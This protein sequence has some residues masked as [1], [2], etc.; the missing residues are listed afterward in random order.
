VR[1]HLQYGFGA[2]KLPEIV[3]VISGS[4]LP[5]QHLAAK[6]GFVPGKLGTYYGHR[7]VLHRS[8]PELHTQAL[9]RRTAVLR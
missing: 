8:T 6:L 5:S 1:S 3:A 2:L 9:R 4:N 7:L